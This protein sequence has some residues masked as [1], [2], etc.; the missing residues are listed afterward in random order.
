MWLSYIYD[1]NT[2]EKI[3][4]Q[5]EGIICFT[6]KLDKQWKLYEENEMS[7][8]PLYCFKADHITCKVTQNMLQLYKVYK[9][10]LG[11]EKEEVLII[12]Q[13]IAYSITEDKLYNTNVSKLEHDIWLMTCPENTHTHT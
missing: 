5:G 10:C 9:S 4:K 11:L 13:L 1:E 8:I 7:Q 2:Y 12:W 3:Y 6:E